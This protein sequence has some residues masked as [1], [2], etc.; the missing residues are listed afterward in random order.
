M[1][2]DSTDARWEALQSSLPEQ[3]GRPRAD[4]QRTLNGILSVFPTRCRWGASAAALRES[5]DL[6]AAASTVAGG[7][8]LGTHRADVSGP[9]E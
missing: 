2:G 4:D 9:V 6:P 3:R 7:G 5:D 1:V 8:R